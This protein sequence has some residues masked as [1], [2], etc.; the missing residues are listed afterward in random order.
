ME[1]NQYKENL[2]RWPRGQNISMKVIKVLGT[3]LLSYFILNFG[4]GFVALST[5]SKY[6]EEIQEAIRFSFIT[7]KYSFKSMKN[8]TGLL[9]KDA[10]NRI[11]ESTKVKEELRE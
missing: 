4:L 3:L 9:I 8:L 7:Q 6:K 10:R 1:S 11:S 5:N 2:S